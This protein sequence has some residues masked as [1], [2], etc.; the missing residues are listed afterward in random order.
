MSDFYADFSRTSLSG[1]IGQ[2]MA[3]LFLEERGYSYVGPF[4]TIIKQ[5]RKVKGRKRY[6]DFVVENKNHWKE[7]AVAETKGKFVSPCSPSNIKGTLRDALEQ[8]DGWSQCFSPPL[9]KSFAIGAFL[10][11]IGDSHRESSLTAFVEMAPGRLRTS[12]GKPLGSVEFPRDAIRRANYASWLS[13]MGFDD[14][15]RRLRERK[16]KPERRSVPLLTLGGRRYTVAITAIRPSY[17][18]HA[19]DLGF[20]R[21]VQE[22]PDGISIELAG[23]DLDVVCALKNALQEPESS[24]ALMEIQPEERPLIPDESGSGEFHGSVFSDGSLIGE[25][26]I[27]DLKRFDLGKDEVAL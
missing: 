7:R 16:G 2:G 25:I 3:L 14:A 22:K 18:H 21:L 17:R 8:L 19:D 24:Q 4:S 5:Y 27:S 20:L 11:E 26:G 15:A 23:L 13:L 10:R 9:H 12:S 6:P 1:R